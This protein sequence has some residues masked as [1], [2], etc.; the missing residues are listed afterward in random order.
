MPGKTEAWLL[1]AAAR[2]DPAALEDCLRA[3]VLQ[4]SDGSL[5]AAV[6]AG[7]LLAFAEQGSDWQPEVLAKQIEQRGFDRRHGVDH[8]AEIKSLL[9]A[10]GG[11][12]VATALIATPAAAHKGTGSD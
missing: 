11:M 12:V 2:P 10:A 1:E 6:D 5:A 8:D 7:T 3:G 4:G 9:A